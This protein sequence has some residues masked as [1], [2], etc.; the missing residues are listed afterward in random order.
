V[1]ITNVAW[2]IIE[3]AEISGTDIKLTSPH[4]FVQELKEQIAAEWTAA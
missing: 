3:V 1:F 4:P 2:G